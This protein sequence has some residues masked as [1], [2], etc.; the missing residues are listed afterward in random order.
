[1]AT[2]PSWKAIDDMV[3]SGHGIPLAPEDPEVRAVRLIWEALDPLE[4]VEQDRVLRWARDRF[5]S[6]TDDRS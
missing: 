5:G 3:R 4:P 6:G 2:E 1:M